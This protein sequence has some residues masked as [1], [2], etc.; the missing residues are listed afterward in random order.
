MHVKYVL[1]NIL[2]TS[3][4]FHVIA[5][6]CGPSFYVK[7]RTAVVGSGTHVKHTDDEL[8]SILQNREPFG[9]GHLL[10]LCVI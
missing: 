2:F 4:H 5:R 6:T 7:I 3:T 9:A 1:S 10:G 8:L